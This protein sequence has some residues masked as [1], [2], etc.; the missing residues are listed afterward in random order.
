MTLALLWVMCGGRPVILRF[1]LSGSLSP[2][3]FLFSRFWTEKTR[4]N[5]PSL[6]W[7]RGLRNRAVV[8]VI[9]EWETF[10][11]EIQITIRQITLNHKQFLYSLYPE[12]ESKS[13][14]VRFESAEWSGIT[15]CVHFCC[16]Q[17]LACSL[18]FSP[19]LLPSFSYSPHWSFWPRFFSDFPILNFWLLYDDTTRLGFVRK[20]NKI[21]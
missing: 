4:S 1:S 9:F 17:V 2:N 19:W 20:G 5:Y 15:L 8:I 7:L 11:V 3:P 13:S 21:S 12:F 18:P 14:I 6:K 10:C 16:R